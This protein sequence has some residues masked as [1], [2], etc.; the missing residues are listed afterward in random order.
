MKLKRCLVSV[1]F[2]LL[3]IFTA[4]DN[5]D[6]KIEVTKSSYTILTDTIYETPVYHFKTNVLGPKILIVGGIHGDEIA[7]WQ[8]ENRLI[9]YDYTFGEI[10]YIPKANILATQLQK[11][12]PGQG[13]NGLYNNISYSDLNR[14]FP[15]KENGTV[16]EQIAN[17]IIKV[18]EEINPDYII[19]LHESKKSYIDGYLGN[20]VIYGNQKSAILAVDIV[21]EFNLQYLP[22]NGVIFRVDSAPPQGSF[23]QYC[24]DNYDAYVLTFETDRQLPLQER[25]DQQMLLIEL[26]FIHSKNH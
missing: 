1:I 8:I 17:A 6:L 20:S 23:N 18:I 24:S 14:V 26:L 7:G 15:G 16:T 21:D 11:R 12:Y 2:L 4:C 10:I 19:D 25:I 5:H 3:M 22:S 9:D 13:T